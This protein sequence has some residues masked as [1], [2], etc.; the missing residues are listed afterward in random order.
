MHKG[1]PEFTARNPHESLVG[2][3]A[4]CNPNTR[5]AK[6]ESTGQAGWPDSTKNSKLQAQL[7]MLPVSIRWTV[8][9]GDD[10]CTQNLH[11]G[12]DACIPHT[13]A[14]CCPKKRE[15]LRF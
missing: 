5:G 12:A 13:C 15:T 7:E 11:T 2:T 9:E 8:T 14:P 6:M 3:V 1:G 4:L 10:P